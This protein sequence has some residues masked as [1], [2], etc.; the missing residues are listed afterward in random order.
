MICAELL[1]FA[2]CCLDKNPAGKFNQLA[3]L[4]HSGFILIHFASART[5]CFSCADASRND[6]RQCFFLRTERLSIRHCIH[7]GKRGRTTEQFRC[8]ASQFGGKT[9]G[10][11]FGSLPPCVVRLVSFHPLFHA[12]EQQ[13]Q[14]AKEREKARRSLASDDQDDAGRLE[15]RRT[16][17]PA[18]C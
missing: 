4:F 10:F 5:P 16:V 13:Q 2:C 7:D 9:L 12:Q 11:F 1:S 3:L 15:Q 14:R 8:F 6:D 18:A 17:P